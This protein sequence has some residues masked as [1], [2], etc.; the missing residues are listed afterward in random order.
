MNE[1]YKGLRPYEEQD[2]DNFFGREVEKHI[3]IDKILTNRL[4]LL[5]AAS[6]VGKSSLL[7]AAVMPELKAPIG[8]NID[9][10]YHKDWFDDPDADLKQTLLTYL[11]N[12]YEISKEAQL[13]PPSSLNQVI[14]F[15]TIFTSEPLVIILDQ[16]EE[17][18]NYQKHKTGF[19][20][21][22]HQLT[23]AILERETPTAFVF[24]MREDFALELN[25]FKPGLPTLLF[26]NFYRL[27]KL[28]K[29]TA[30]EAIEK[31]VA[32]LGFA[33]EPGLLDTLLNDL[34]RREQID[35]FGDTVSLTETMDVVEPPHLQI[36]CLQL[37]QA[38]KNNSNRL[39]TKVTYENKDKATGLLTNYFQTQVSQLSFV[40]KQLASLSFNYLV[41]K[42]GT[43]IAYPLQE[44]AQRL[45]VEEK[46]LG[47]TLDKLEQARIL[48]KQK[49]QQ[50]IWYEL[51]H[52]I[53]SKNIF[54]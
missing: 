5:F 29:D 11:K 49:R 10:V 54:Q 48:R 30:K 23:K 3:L 14:Q 1:P 41:N 43:K 24:S 18:F 52:D 2:Q 6:G 46:T 16:F 17:F 9:V 7:Q 33:Y 27:E 15:C 37:W 25:A 34:S 36:V 12:N 50:I 19:K 4:T 28:T 45:R 22:I 26:N 31:P 20:P 40:D 32:Q 47:A 38:D 51:Y 35:S 53:F 39:I 8:E 13:E 21:F 42:Q 44:L